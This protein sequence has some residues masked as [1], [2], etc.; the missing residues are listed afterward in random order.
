[1][2][3]TPLAAAATRNR[4]SSVARQWRERDNSTHS[5]HRHAVAQLRRKLPF[6]DD[7]A[8]VFL[9]EPN[10]QLMTVMANKMPYIGRG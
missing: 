5:E 1:L 9:L 4:H 3:P 10:V 8:L 6:P 7:E 2:T